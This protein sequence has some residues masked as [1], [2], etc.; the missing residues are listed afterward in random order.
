MG[1]RSSSVESADVSWI[2]PP[3]SD[4]VASRISKISGGRMDRPMIARFYG[5]SS[6]AGFST[7]PVI[8]TTRSDSLSRSPATIPY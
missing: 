2:S 6:G 1:R 7:I 4:R 3:T 5:A 8:R